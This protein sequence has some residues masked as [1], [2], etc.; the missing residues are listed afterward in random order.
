MT[1]G[2]ISFATARATQAE[3]LA[4]VVPRIAARLAELDADGRLVGPGPVFVGIGASHAAAAAPV[5]SLR[6]RGVHS[7]RLSAGDQPL[8]FPVSTHPIIGVSQS[9][10]SAETLAVL[11]SVPAELRFAMVNTEPSPIAD[12]ASAVIGLG[13]LSD[14]YASTIGYT[15][16]VAALGMI[17]DVWD[18]GSVEPGW[19]ELGEVFART[20][21]ALGDEV[22]GLAGLFVD[23]S[24]ADFVGAGPAVGSAEAGALLLREVAR[25]PST[26]MST[27]QY[28]HGSME[29]A[30]GGVHVVFGDQRELDL[31]STLSQ[32][33]HHVI[34]VTSEQLAATSTLHPVR[35]PR[36]PAAQRAAI[37]ALVLQLLAGAVADA[38][39]VDIEEF[40]FHNADTKVDVSA[41][42]SE[43]ADTTDAA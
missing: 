34:L 26:G 32:A 43:G 19:A 29:S 15:A 14:S 25:I 31:A 27:R 40:V 20:E 3:E 10:R 1:T 36:L 16:T 37:E 5:W 35:V 24:S 18:R 11:E 23:A 12:I 13:S 17:A 39:G 7:W 41:G 6:S 9:G 21:A 42:A 22:R 8:P 33:G 4:A 28:L 2:Y 30:G 38:R